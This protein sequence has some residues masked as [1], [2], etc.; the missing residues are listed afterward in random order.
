M[1]YTN[2]IVYSMIYI[3]LSGFNFK[4]LKIIFMYPLF[5]MRPGKKMINYAC[6]ASLNLVVIQSD[7][8]IK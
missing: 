5:L 6:S 2:Y 3:V 4:I 8:R 1:F 7:A